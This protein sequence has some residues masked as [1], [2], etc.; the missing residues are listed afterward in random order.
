ML[1]LAAVIDWK[2]YRKSLFV[3]L[4]YPDVKAER[5]MQ[6]RGR[7]R[8]LL[9]RH[10]ENYL[11]KEVTCVWRIEWQKRKSGSRIGEWLPHVHLLMLGLPFLPHA[12][13]RKWWGG[14]LQYSGPLAT[15]VRAVQSGKAA[16]LYVSKYVA[17]VNPEHSL[18]NVSYLNTS[19]RHWGV[20]RRKALKTH[21]PIVFPIMTQEMITIAKNAGCMVVP[22]FNR[23]EDKGFFLLGTMAERVGQILLKMDVD[24]WERRQ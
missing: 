6:E 4:T 11:G 15:D 10:V 14:C 2:R 13:L 8:Y 24:K 20:S 21:P 7:D 22:W 5:T 9:L 1:Q 3:T 12:L 17:K 16:S 18:D 23:E 19:G